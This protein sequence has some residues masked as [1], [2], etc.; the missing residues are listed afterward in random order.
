MTSPLF[1]FDPSRDAVINPWHYDVPPG[2]PDRAVA[3]WFGDV[4]RYD[5]VT[6][7]EEEH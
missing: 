7:S 2:L 5:M 1:E 4:V 3:C 6:I